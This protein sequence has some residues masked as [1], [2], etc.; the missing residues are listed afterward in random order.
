M[1]LCFL[2]WHWQNMG[3]KDFTEQKQNKQKNPMILTIFHATSPLLK[4]IIGGIWLWCTWSQTKTNMHGLS[5]T[6]PSS[7]SWPQTHTWFS[8]PHWWP[9]T[10]KHIHNSSLVKKP[11]SWPTWW[12]HASK[13]TNK[14]R[15]HHWNAARH[16]PG[17]GRHRSMQGL[18]F[19]SVWIA[20]IW[21][22]RL[23]GC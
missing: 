7:T 21:P 8:W 12:P 16:Q 11:W 14:Y 22:S 15:T 5:V 1:C 20:L 10:R 6:W 4:L 19:D 2:C 3:C 18:C 17:Q 13:Q 23:S 9:Q